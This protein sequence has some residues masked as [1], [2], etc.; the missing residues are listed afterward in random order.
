MSLSSRVLTVALAAL[1]ISP[2]VASA[3]SIVYIK[4][5]NVWLAKPD[6]TG[7]YQVT[8]DGTAE[9][10]YR[11][12][13]QADDGTIAVGHGERILRMRQ[14]GAVLNDL[15]PPTLMNSVSHPMDGVPVDVAISPD[16]RKIAYSFVG[17][18]CPVGASC[19]TRYVTGIIP[20]DRFSATATYGSSYFHNPS[21]VTNSRILN[22]GGFGS[23]IN[24]QD[25]GTEPFNWVTDMETDLGD[26]EVTRQGDKLVAVRGY[27]SST[28][29]VWYRVN[30]NVL[31]GGKPPAPEA[32]CQTG[33]AAGFDQPNWSPDGNQVAW[34]EPD[35]IWVHADAAGCTSPQPKLVLPG[36]SESD[37]GPA[38]VNPGPRPVPEQP[39]GGEQPSGGGRPG[40]PVVV[41]PPAT[42]TLSVGKAKVRGKK[43]RLSVACSGRCA[44]TAK[45]TVDKRTA[46]KLHV[47]RVLAK[48]SGTAK[49]GAATITLKLSGK[50]ARA[51]KK[52][53]KRSRA[54][55]LS[56]T[57]SSGGLK[58]TRTTVVKPR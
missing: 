43:V 7:S 1:A 4:D 32:T 28:H 47:K 8:T 50:S 48:V 49:G 16:G 11:S 2:A 29:I 34:T 33:E 57:A 40:G 54:L 3:D 20:S 24:I 45:L 15:D 44:Y 35:G 39:G 31:F 18:E 56:V 55:R 12:P 6:G 5:S 19:G 51:L 46:K 25:L 36:G 37:W 17:Y 42:L 38:N 13:S 26:A 30:G 10:P 21:W 53:G 22:S 58:S 41:D 27:G 9:H 14:N 23:H 52:L